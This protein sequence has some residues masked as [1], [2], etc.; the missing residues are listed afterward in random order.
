VAKASIYAFPIALGSIILT[1][2]HKRKTPPRDPVIVCY[3]QIF[4]TLLQLGSTP[5]VQP[6]GIIEITQEF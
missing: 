4:Y 1:L 2:A 6:S 5:P 3:K